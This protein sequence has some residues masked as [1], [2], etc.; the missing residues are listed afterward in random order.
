VNINSAFPSNYIKASDLNGAA[1]VVTIADVKVEGVGRDKE[2]KPVVYFVGKQKGMVL[3]RT[4]SKKIADIAGSQDT[5][6][7]P[8]TKIA[9][10][11]TTTEFGG[12]EVEC[13]RIKAPKAAE[14]PKPAPE[15]V[16][17]SEEDSIPF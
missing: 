12:E 8:G 2:V 6:D 13:I 17:D 3:N 4:N 7:W 14:K 5:E 16:D 9:I 15:P 1:V 11:P 10:Y